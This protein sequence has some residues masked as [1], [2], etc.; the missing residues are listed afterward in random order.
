MSYRVGVDIGG[1]FVDFCLFEEETGNLITFKK[2]TTP[3]RPGAEVAEG[4]DALERQY[5]VRAADIVGFVH[6]TTVGINTVIQRNGARLALF[7]TRNF[8]DVLE[9]ARLRMPETYSLF[10]SR[11]DPLVPRKRIFGIRER[12]LADG[13]VDEPLDEESVKKALAAARTRGVEGIVISFINGYRNPR[14]EVAVQEILARLAPDLFTFRST[15]VWPVVRE[16]ER[17]TATAINGYVHP[18]VSGYLSSL[19]ASLRERGVQ[20]EPLITKSNGGLMKAELGKRECAQMILSGTASGVM[21]ASWI[22]AEAGIYDAITLDIGGTSADVALVTGGRPRFGT[23]EKIGELPLYIPT[24]SVSSIGE[25]GG[26]IAWIDSFG[27]LKVGPRSAGSEPGPACYGRGGVEPTITDAF[28]VCGYLGHHELAYDSVRPDAK[29]ARN[30]VRPIA[31]GLGLGLEAAAEAII[32]VAVSGML[33][34][35]NKM[36]ARYGVDQRELALMPFGG[37]GPMLGC[38][39]AREL[40]SRRVLVPATPGVV[41]A[42]GGLVADVRNDFIRTLSAPVDESSAALFDR[43]VGDLRAAG[44]K[45]LEEDQGLHETVR[46]QWFADMS[47]RNQSFEIE[48]AL[49]AEWLEEQDFAA[50][51]EAFHTAHRAIYDFADEAAPMQIVNLRL[52]ASI[53]TPKPR[54]ARLDPAGSTLQASSTLTVFADGAPCRMPLYDR[55]ALRAGHC[56]AGPSIVAQNDTTVCI[57][58]GF[59][60]EVDAFGNILLSIADR[61]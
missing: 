22:A 28:V 54:I 16:Y 13:S 27:V 52:V 49:K 14:H 6:G 38:F 51:R 33:M 34:E 60:A 19:Q 8:E 59:D 5:G 9:L 36:V 61:S 17:T 50:I 11:P 30:A 57:P 31:E 21:G 2:L 12:M 7:T 18:K 35:I 46:E 45:W 42:L 15:E 3:S 55:A 53:T 41:S 44:R 37:A 47:Y 26:S 24:V 48:V 43:H 58:A 39:L 20:P 4:L 29:K 56:F 10:S 23:G 25:G 32:K 40:G 1:T